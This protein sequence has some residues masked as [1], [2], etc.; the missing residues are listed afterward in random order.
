MPL[1]HRRPPTR[2]PLSAELRTVLLHG[3][4]AAGKTPN[5]FTHDTLRELWRVHGP[6][7]LASKDC[8]T[9]PWFPERDA[10]V[11]YVRREV[12]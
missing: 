7:L 6:A 3:P 1:T 4:H 9:Q 5:D 11:T 10:F 8:P 12:Q 2:P